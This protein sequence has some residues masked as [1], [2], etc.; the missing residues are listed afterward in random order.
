[1]T[2]VISVHFVHIILFKTLVEPELPHKTGSAF[3]RIQAVFI[4]V[5]A[6]LG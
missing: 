6:N 2:E 5:Y 4:C 1:M 3:L